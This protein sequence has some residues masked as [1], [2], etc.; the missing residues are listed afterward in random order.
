MIFDAILAFLLAIFEATMLTAIGTINLIAI[1]I[2]FVVGIFV[3]GFKL[4]RVGWKGK[5]S[6]VVYL[7]TLSLIH[8]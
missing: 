8:I 1:C 5:G 3:S 7:V 2:E 6:L 4:G